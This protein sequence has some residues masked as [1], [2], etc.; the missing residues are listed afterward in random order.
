MREGSGRAARAG[1]SEPIGSNRKQSEAPSEAIRS[2]PKPH[3][4]QSEA[5]RRPVRSNR[6]RT[7]Q[8]GVVI[9][10]AVAPALGLL[11]KE[12]LG[13]RRERAAAYNKGRALQLGGDWKASRMRL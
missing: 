13:R 8:V 9:D 5:I 12:V 2:N 11:P 6:P 10:Q 7:E 1:L 3:P 4:K